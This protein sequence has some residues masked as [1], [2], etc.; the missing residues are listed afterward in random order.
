M[1]SLNAAARQGFLNARRLSSDP[2][3]D[4]LAQRPDFLALARSISRS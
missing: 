2:L 4:S 1:T 3:L